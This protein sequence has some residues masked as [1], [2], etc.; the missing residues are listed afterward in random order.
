MSANVLPS[1]AQAQAQAQSRSSLLRLPVEI[2]R[3][4]A[5]YLVLGDLP[6]PAS[7]G[8][9]FE[10]SYVEALRRWRQTVSIS[11]LACIPR[12]SCSSRRGARSGQTRTCYVQD[13]GPPHCALDL[14]AV[15]HYLR[16]IVHADAL[17]WG[18][19]L[20]VHPPFLPRA[21]ARAMCAHVP[22]L[23]FTAHGGACL[24]VLDL[25]LKH[26]ECVTRIDMALPST[27]R[28]D[29]CSPSM[30]I[31]Q[32]LRN[33]APVLEH[34]DLRFDWA[35]AH[36]DA[37][38]KTI[39]LLPAILTSSLLNATFAIGGN[40]LVSLYVAAEE[41]V[42]R[43]M[44]A[45]IYRVLRLC[46]N[47]RTLSL[48]MVLLDFQALTLDE[49]LR[50]PNAGSVALPHLDYLHI[51]DTH[52]EWMELSRSL[53]IPSSCRV[54]A[55]VTLPMST[56]I[57]YSVAEFE[58][59]CHVSLVNSELRDI[60][61]RQSSVALRVR[62]TGTANAE[63]QWPEYMTV[64]FGDNPSSAVAFRE[65]R[66]PGSGGSFTVRN[67]ALSQ[68]SSESPWLHL[69]HDGVRTQRTLEIFIRGCR[70]LG[71]RH[72]QSLV[73]DAALPFVCPERW[74]MLLAE[75]P[76]IKTICI[77]GLTTL[78]SPHLMDLAR[79][80]GSPFAPTI[81]LT[82]SLLAPTTLVFPCRQLR[83]IVIPDLVDELRQASISLL[84][85]SL[86]PRLSEAAYACL[87]AWKS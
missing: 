74:D 19:A 31:F 50:Y 7:R 9:P 83:Q 55:D 61:V 77:R 18:D 70:E 30:M 20:L 59:A 71:L 76:D 75:F 14:T 85:V 67:S 26:M 87:I 72:V 52:L 27:N 16:E 25:L 32:E 51:S 54:H 22:R 15:C 65:P 35:H 68:T 43:W 11:P 53:T 60:G 80:L 82:G 3:R 34:V 47:L 44:R 17:F 84:N 6:A 12:R 2:L 24:C 64:S 1:Q 21:I 28:S 45:D 33:G 41:H 10:D 66:R 58:R 36:A 56:R 46:P 38:K 48:Q 23:A 81:T 69:K 4:I 40:T 86:R 63:W 29:T 8:L 79:A 73:V 57:G 37:S 42:F 13:I 78:K 39:I 62:D 5:R 49:Q